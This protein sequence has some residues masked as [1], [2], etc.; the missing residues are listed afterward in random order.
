MGGRLTDKGACPTCS[1]F[2]GRVRRWWYQQVVGG[3]HNHDE[4]EM[5]LDCHGC[6]DEVDGRYL[7]ERCS[8]QRGHAGRLQPV[9]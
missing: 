1:G 7:C 4:L 9:C 6:L 5:S 2:Q 8:R 3:V